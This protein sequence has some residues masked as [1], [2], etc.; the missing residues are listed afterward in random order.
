ML[1]HG[2]IVYAD[3]PFIQQVHEGPYD[4]TRFTETG[5]RYLFR[6]FERV[7]TGSVAGAGTALRWSI[8]Y[9]VRALTRSVTVGRIVGLCF[10]W[11]SYLDRFLDP[12][13]SVDAANSVFFLGR[14][15]ATMSG[16]EGVAYYQGGMQGR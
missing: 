14:N 4:F 3:T 1:R 8:D 11:L 5:H 7:D 2:G 9:F 13:D 10:F 15:G 12:K 16:A 6:D